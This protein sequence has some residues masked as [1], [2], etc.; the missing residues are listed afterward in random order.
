MYEKSI[1][2]QKENEFILAQLTRRYRFCVE[3]SLWPQRQGEDHRTP[4]E[5]TPLSLSGH[6]HSF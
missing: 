5:I 2:M 6:I 4:L 3:I 1:T